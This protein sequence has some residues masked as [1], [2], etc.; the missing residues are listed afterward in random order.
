MPV[1]VTRRNVIFQ[2][3]ASRVIA[4]FFYNGEERGMELVQ[5]ILSMPEKQQREML[6]QVLRDFSKRHRSISKVF[7]KNFHKLGSILEKISIDP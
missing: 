1:T 5:T 4:R 3:D 2:P 6:V 7:E